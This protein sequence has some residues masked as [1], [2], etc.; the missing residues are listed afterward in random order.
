[1]PPWLAIGVAAQDPDG[2]RV[3]LGLG[4]TVV[5]TSQI[6]HHLPDGGL[7][8]HAEVAMQ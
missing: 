6:A 7:T 2:L 4:A 1:M 8:A 5:V 3:G